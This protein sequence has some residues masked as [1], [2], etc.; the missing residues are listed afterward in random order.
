[1]IKVIITKGKLMDYNDYSIDE[2]ALI[3]SN[4]KIV[5]KVQ[6]RNLNFTSASITESRLAAARE[7]LASR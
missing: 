1:M 6:K 2:L 4:L 5:L 7:E 3:I